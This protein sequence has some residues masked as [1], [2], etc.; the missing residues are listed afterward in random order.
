M[1][2]AH[3]RRF[4]LQRLIVFLIVALFVTALTG[5]ATAGAGKVKLNA[6]KAFLTAQIALLSAQQTV[7]AACSIPNPPQPICN[8]AIDLVHTGA[9]A[10]TAGFT[11]QKAGNQK[12]LQAAIAT[13]N[14]LPAQL[15]TLGLIKRSN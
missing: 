2:Y 7:A 1:T 13:L 15:V 3:W 12:D 5:C 11:A 4:E 9:Q 8:T 14:D 10:E 6:N